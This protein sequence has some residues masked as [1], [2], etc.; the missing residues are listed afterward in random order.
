MYNTKIFTDLLEELNITL[1][2]NQIEQFIKYYEILI[3]RNKV[4]NLTAITDYDEVIRKHFVDSLSI[5]KVHEMN[6]N[7]RVLDMGTGAGFPGIPLKIAFPNLEIVLIDSLNKRINFL[8]DVIT[9]LGLEKISALHG[10]AEDFGHKTGFRESFDLCVSRAVAKLSTLSEY[11]MPYVKKNGSFIPY[12]AGNIQTELDESKDAIFLLGGKIETIS[13]FHLP[14]SDIERTLLVINKVKST[15]KI[16]P[17]TAG[18]PAKEP[19]K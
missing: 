15:P 11:C 14:Q 6:Q 5:V 18:K 8:N 2:D 4:M 16:Y 19:I 13:S 1:S 7:I 9:E 12:K 17:R 10:R 3:E